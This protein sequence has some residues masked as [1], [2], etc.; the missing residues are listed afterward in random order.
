MMT[1]PG[2]IDYLV[3]FCVLLSLTAY[4]NPILTESEMESDSISRKLF[5]HVPVSKV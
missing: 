3:V 5:N 4:E 2:D 1:C